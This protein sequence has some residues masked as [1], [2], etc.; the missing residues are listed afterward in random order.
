MTLIQTVDIV[1]LVIDGAARP[2]RGG[3]RAA[4]LDPATGA[5]LAEVAAAGPEDVDD[6]VA[7][8]RAAQPAWSR[9]SPRQRGQHLFAVAALVRR[10]ADDLAHTESLDTGKPLAQA[11]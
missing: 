4:V 9:L 2:A 6:A 8:A 1:D 5:T 3:A 11:R 7:A 10:H